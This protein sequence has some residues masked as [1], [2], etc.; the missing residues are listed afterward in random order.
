[1]LSVR[2]LRAK[3]GKLGNHLLNSK[4]EHATQETKGLGCSR[5]ILLIFFR[6]ITLVKASY[7]K[8]RV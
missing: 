5:G 7:L 6:V 8:D 2:Q 4:R 1:M 3:R